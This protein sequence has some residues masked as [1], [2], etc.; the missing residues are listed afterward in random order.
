[1]NTSRLVM[2]PIALCAVGKAE[3]RSNGSNRKARTDIHTD[4]RYQV[5]YLTRLAINKY[6][7][8]IC[9]WL[10]GTSLWLSVLNC[11]L[12]PNLLSR[13]LLSLNPSWY[14]VSLIMFS[15]CMF[16][17]PACHVMS[18]RFTAAVKLLSSSS[19]GHWK[20]QLLVYNHTGILVANFMSTFS[21]RFSFYHFIFSISKSL[22]DP[23]FPSPHSAFL[24]I[25]S[26]Y[27]QFLS[28]LDSLSESYCMQ[29]HWMRLN[30][31][32]SWLSMGNR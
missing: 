21:I 22:W 20:Y 9:K 25:F 11:R 12:I 24:P 3:H 17:G 29:L 1:M 6:R 30:P 31:L 4:V 14:M 2:T 23:R 13:L 26:F 32:H 18:P 19:L 28:R 8:M 15:D 27:A 16:I 10:P 5:H 7:N